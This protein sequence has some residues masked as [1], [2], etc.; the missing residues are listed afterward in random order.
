LTEIAFMNDLNPLTKA[1]IP[2]F[3]RQKNAFLI[4]LIWAFAAGAEAQT[5]T[6]FQQLMFF[7]VAQGLGGYPAGGVALGK[8]GQIYTGT[9][10]TST[11]NAN[12]G[13]SI[14]G[15]NA[16][17]TAH[18]CVTTQPYPFD[19]L[20][21]LLVADDGTVFGTTAG[22]VFRVNPDGSGYT[23]LYTFGDDF[24]D[25]GYYQLSGVVFGKDGALY[26]NTVYGG[27]YGEGVIFKVNTDGTVYQILHD[28]GTNAVVGA[29]VDAQEPFGPL[30]VGPDGALYGTGRHGGS[31]ATNYPPGLGAIFRL[32]PDGSGYSVLRSFDGS[33]GAEVETPLTFGTDGLL[34]GTGIGIFSL[35]ADGAGFSETNCFTDLESLQPSGLTLGPDGAFYGTTEFGGNTNAAYPALTDQAA[36]TLGTVFRVNMDGTGF[37]TLYSFGGEDGR[38]PSGLLAVAGDGTIYGT[39]QLGGYQ[40]QGTVFKLSSAAPAAVSIIDT[41]FQSGGFLLTFS[42]APSQSWVVQGS[43]NLASTNGWQ[44]LAATNT[45]SFGLFQ[46][47]DASAT[48]NPASGFYRAVQ[49]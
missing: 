4:L 3:R 19:L 7:Y 13:G 12:T 1:T 37:E 42:G 2:P 26:G 17:G 16:N 10:G 15:V 5:Q 33:D 47:L 49:Q 23:N 46:F 25:D 8:N 34:H 20:G 21:T 14:V 30:C 41:E 35:G 11:N 24:D 38:N 31:S 6:N 28:F 22:S 43:S 32:N 48:N 39:T 40:D 18:S 29:A 44:G 9:I 36:N 27:A 45:D